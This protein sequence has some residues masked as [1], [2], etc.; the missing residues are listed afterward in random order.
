MKAWTGDVQERALRNKH[1]L[2]EVT[3]NSLPGT[4]GMLPGNTSIQNNLP[5]LLEFDS[6][7]MILQSFKKLIYYL[8]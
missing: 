2:M 7:G 1:Q 6:E 4:V 5:D 8:E 3:V